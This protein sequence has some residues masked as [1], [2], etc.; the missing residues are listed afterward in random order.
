MPLPTL[1]MAALARSC[2]VRRGPRPDVARRCRQLV[3]QHLSQPAA[4]L[5]QRVGLRP[6]EVRAAQGI[7]RSG[8]V[9]KG[10]RIADRGVETEFVD[11]VGATVAGVVDVDPV[12]PVVTELEEI[13]STGGILE[14]DVIADVVTVSGRSGLGR[15]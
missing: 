10:V 11:D 4:H 13:G 5:R 3:A 9:E 1:V 8:V 2:L 15:G 7:D 6:V 14:W 12:Q